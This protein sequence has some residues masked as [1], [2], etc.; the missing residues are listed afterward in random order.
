MSTEIKNQPD[1]NNV[2]S[3]IKDGL[4]KFTAKV[5]VGAAL[6]GPMVGQAAENNHHDVGNQTEVS[7]KGEMPS[8][9]LNI[10][11]RE[12]KL[13]LVGRLT[14]DL[15]VDVFTIPVDMIN[16]L[17]LGG[18]E[19]K[20]T[21]YYEELKDFGCEDEDRLGL[22]AEWLNIVDNN[23]TGPFRLGGDKSFEHEQ[24]EDYITRDQILDYAVTG[25]GLNVYLDKNNSPKF[26]LVNMD[27]EATENFYKAIDFLESVGAGDVVKTLTENGVNTFF[28]HKFDKDNYSLTSDGVIN[29]HGNKFGKTSSEDICMALLE[30]SFAIKLS[31]LSDAG[32]ALFSSHIRVLVDM[33]AGSNW[34]YLHNKSNRTDMELLAL[35][36]EYREKADIKLE[37]LSIPDSDVY[38]DRLYRFITETNLVKPLGTNNWN[39][40]KERTSGRE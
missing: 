1:I 32:V 6:A 16:E 4:K 38:I 15:N 14:S 2:S 18:K 26:L 29:I 7:L 5:L 33:M 17:A 31:Q 19:K 39:F 23:N 25:D 8:V 21:P 9:D 13:M 27:N 36:T 40:L 30:Q 10:S 22:A 12:T 34:E 11:D 35:A 24:V 37:S 28:L 20:L 3:S